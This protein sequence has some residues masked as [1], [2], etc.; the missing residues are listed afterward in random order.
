VYDHHDLDLTEE[1]QHKN[2]EPTVYKLISTVQ[3]EGKPIEGS[4]KCMVNV[5]QLGVWLELQDLYNRE[6]LEALVQ[7]SAAY[8]LFF[9]RVDS[10]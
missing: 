9:E 6:T 10:N 7:T 1:K 4:Y 3:H 5:K 8:M 2:K